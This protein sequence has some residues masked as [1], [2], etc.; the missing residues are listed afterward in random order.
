MRV[1]GL[2]PKGLTT[3]NGR[4]CMHRLRNYDVRLSVPNQHYK[5]MLEVIEEVL[6][7]GDMNELIWFLKEE[8]KRHITE[9]IL[10][11]VVDFN[12]RLFKD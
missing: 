10:N 7:K 3:I 6:K 9:R 4:V 5:V 8:G 2:K 12:E 11:L 1:T